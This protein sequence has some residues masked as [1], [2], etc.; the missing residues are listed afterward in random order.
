MSRRIRPRESGARFCEPVLQAV[1]D[2]QLDSQARGEAFSMVV[3]QKKRRRYPR[4][5][6][7]EV[8]AGLAEPDL[9]VVVERARIQRRLRQPIF[10]RTQVRTYLIVYLPVGKL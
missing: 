6:E 9:L 8:P 1:S 4:V 2:C 5:R 3:V 7:E 10:V